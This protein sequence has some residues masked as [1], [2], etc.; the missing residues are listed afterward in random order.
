[1]DTMMDIDQLRRRHKA[2]LVEKA[3]KIFCPEEVGQEV[4]IYWLKRLLE[5]H[6]VRQMLEHL[7]HG[8]SRSL[9]QSRSGGV[10]MCVS[11][12]GVEVIDQD[13]EFHADG[14]RKL[15][16]RIEN[17][18]TSAW[19]TTPEQPLYAAY[20][21]YDETGDVHDFDGKR[22]PLPKP[23]HPGDTLPM[24]ID[25][26]NP[27]A[28]GDYRLMV[29]MVMEGQFWMEEKEL[30]IHHIPITVLEYDGDGLTRQARDLYHQLK[31]SVMEAA[32]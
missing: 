3:L 6:D 23:I 4:K 20:H 15:W 28:P 1:M 16:V 9:E 22:T 21:W 10:E 31:R 27:S 19:E 25:I 24:E 8:H 32:H 13:L 29:T 14:R 30:D 26:V 7:K 17:G 12:G 18:S 2:E 5:G 11:T